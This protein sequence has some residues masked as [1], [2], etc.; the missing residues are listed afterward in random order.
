MSTGGKGEVTALGSLSPG[1]CKAKCPEFPRTRPCDGPCDGAGMGWS[2]EKLVEDHLISK[3]LGGAT[4]PLE[5]RTLVG[6]EDLQAKD[7]SEW[8]RPT[9]NPGKTSAFNFS[10]AWRAQSQLSLV[11]LSWSRA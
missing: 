7:P 8:R 10:Q 5:W 1:V 4:W 9:N 2:T 3:G 6:R 11:W